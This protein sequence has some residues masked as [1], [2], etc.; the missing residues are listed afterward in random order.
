VRTPL[1]LFGLAIVVRLGLVAL[2]PDPA[3]PDSYYY[4]EVARSLAAGHG[5]SVPFIWVF[6]EVGNRIPDAPVLPIPSNAHWLPLSSIIQVPSIL[7]LG[8]TPLAYA[9]P[10]VI[11]SATAAPLTW[12]IARDAGARQIVATGAGVLAA[13][14]AAGAVFLGQPENYA[15]LLPLVT[16]T[17]WLVARGLKGSAV[18][19]VFAGLLAGLAALSR[20]DGIFLLGAIGLVWLGDRARWWLAGRGGASR[21]ARGSASVAGP[22]ARRP[23][24]LSAAVGCV[25]LFLLVIGP[26]WLRQIAVFGSI[27]PTSTSGAAVWFRDVAEWNSIT[28]DTTF[29]GFLSQGIGPIVASRVGG[30]VAAVAIFAVVMC[31]VVLLPFLVVGAWL[32]RR[33]VDFAPW[34]VYAAVVFLAA[35]LVYPVFVPSGSFI[36]SSIGLAPYAYILALEGVLASVGWVAHRRRSWDAEA[37]GRIFVWAT[38]AF[39]V[40]AAVPFGM[41]AIAAWDG[42]RQPRVALAAELD[43]LGV[44]AT[45]R[46]LSIDPGGMTY[47][48]GRPGVVTPNDPLPTIEAVA[49]A[50]GTR[51]LVLERGSAAPSLAPVLTGASRPSWIGAPVFEV[52]AGDGGLPRLSLY[53]VCTAVAD[54]RCGGA[55]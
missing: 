37:A 6:A 20:N 39:A 45:D 5:F 51:W 4:V 32:R 30:L 41:G 1:L 25:A 33:S 47:W 35:A 14:P 49:T 11:I 52:P 13:I 40:L 54:D 22:V 48:T 19:F 7:L 27:S 10:R 46:L 16:A 17:L 2:F 26:W 8:P 38:V 24:P 43:R 34:F 3:Y 53:P 15:L 12:A 23:V 31:S 55:P 36:H 29:S 21:S 50:Y 18:S 28:S 42:M 9:L 44:P